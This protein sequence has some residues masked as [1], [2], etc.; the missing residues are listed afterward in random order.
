[1]I[2]P[3]SSNLNWLIPLQTPLCPKV[4]AFLAQFNW[5]TQALNAPSLSRMRFWLQKL[6]NPHLELKAV[7]VGGTNGKGSVVRLLEGILQAAGYKT[8][9]TISPHLV[10]VRERI[11]LN[12]APISND[13][14][15]EAVQVLEPL[16]A[17]EPVDAWPTYF[18]VLILL[19]FWV[20]KAQNVDVVLIEVGLGGL[21]DAT[22]VL[23]NPLAT[24]I[25]SLGYDHTEWL[26][27]TLEAIATQKAGIFK[28]NCPVILGPALPDEARGVFLE[29][30]K[31]TQPSMIMEATAESFHPAK[32]GLGGQAVR[33]LV[34]GETWELCLLGTHQRRNLA[35]VLA[36]VEV[37]NRNGLTLPTTAVKQGLKTAHW[38]ARLDYLPE[39]GLLIDGS[40]NEQGLKALAD[41]LK[42]SLPP[43]TG[44]F[45]LVSLRKN[46]SVGPLEALLKTFA[47]QTLGVICT[48][49]SWDSTLYHNP[50]SLRQRFRDNLDGLNTRPIWAATH[51]QAG[52][53]ML[54]K[55]LAGHK[56]PNALPQNVLGVVTG[57]LYT[58]GAVYQSL[59]KVLEGPS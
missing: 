34:S 23:E 35:T 58:A 38:P 37:L 49:A 43:E 2:S 8:G 12:G 21:F 53:W 4:A 19:A 39:Q 57:S 15:R 3:Q 25:T 7:H 11:S 59:Y 50:V 9:A 55:W 28:P 13:V 30:A 18:E 22:N 41:S 17:K 36:T 6:G 52:L 14:L 40:H 29:T 20:F 51:P 48:Q 26:G 10:D 56:T 45:W 46:R 54:Q 1:M 24:I 5:Q 44:L 33:N 27:D 32:V 47:S 42:E 31:T 16:L